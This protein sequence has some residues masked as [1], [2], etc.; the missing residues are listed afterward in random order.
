MRLPLISAA[1]LG[2]S[3]LVPPAPASAAQFSGL[4]T[5]LPAQAQSFDSSLVQEVRYR[6]RRYYRSHRSDGGAAAAGAIIGLALGAII[7]SQATQYN[8]SVEWCMQRYRS[9]NPR[10]GTW[11]DYK[12]RVRR[13]P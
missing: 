1:V 12:G 4:S 8:R 13:C 5:S 3:L 10:T 7:A 11:I 2:A 6:G 9:Y